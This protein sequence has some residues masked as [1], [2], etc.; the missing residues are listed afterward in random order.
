MGKGDKRSFR[1]KLSRGSFGKCRP[2]K[3]AK[4]A[5]KPVEAGGETAPAAETTS[6]Q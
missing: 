2:R 6:G 1:G 5:G 4:K 3:P